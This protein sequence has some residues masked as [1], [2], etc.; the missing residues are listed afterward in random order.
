MTEEINYR[1]AIARALADEMAAD[2]AVIL[3]GEDIGAAGGAFKSTPGLFERFG[4]A[5]VRDTPISEQA[6]V[7]AAA[8]AAMRGLRPVAEI[9]FADFAGV[10]FDQIANQVA[11]YRYMTGGQVTLPVTIRMANGAGA[12][13]G[14]QHSQATENWFLGIPGL[15]IAVPGTVPDLYGLL[16]SAIRDDNPVLVF[17]HK[18]LFAV[19]GTIPSGDGLVPLGKADVARHG[20]DV[21]I[22]ATQQMRWRALEAAGQLAAEGIEAAVIDPRTLVPF[23]DDAVAESLQT[24][25]RLTVVQEAPAGSGWGAALIARM[26]QQHFFLFDAP[27][28]LI[29][30]DN[31]PIPYAAT[32]EAAWLPTAERITSEVRKQVHS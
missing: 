22:V 9:M 18:N 30:G 12:G 1:H 31:T 10:C 32:L 13:F 29:G 11:K 4:P 25:S 21:T 27:P 26:T 24:T 20:T 15:K 16:R 14:A 23:D 6:I 7:G 17:E 5:R 3:I 2:P 19:K 8:G 28:L